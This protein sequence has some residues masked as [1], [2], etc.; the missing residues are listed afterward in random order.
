[1][2]VRAREHRDG[3]LPLRT[4]GQLFEHAPFRAQ[5]ALQT[6]GNGAEASPLRTS[7][8]LPPSTPHTRNPF[9]CARCLMQAMAPS[10]EIQ[11]EEIKRFVEE[12]F[13]GGEQ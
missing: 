9:D 7:T 10:G 4:D 13:A 5:S 1:M 6:N 3:S 12:Q 2:A 11:P 8:S